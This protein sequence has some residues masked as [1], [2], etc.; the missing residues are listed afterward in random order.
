[1]NS[2]PAKYESLQET[3]YWLNEEALSVMLNPS[4]YIGSMVDTFN[5]D[6][7]IKILNQAKTQLLAIKNMKTD[8]MEDVINRFIPFYDSISSKTPFLETAWSPLVIKS[9]YP[10]YITDFVQTGFN[11]IH[12]IA[13]KEPKAIERFKI[14][15]L[16]A[17]NYLGS[18]VVKS[19]IPYS[20][21]IKEI[22]HYMYINETAPKVVD[23]IMITQTIYPFLKTLGN[24]CDTKIQQIDLI[25]EGMMKADDMLKA[26]PDI[27]EA[28]FST[29]DRLKY[30][31]SLAKF[32][33]E[34]KR[35]FLYIT[36]VF[37]REASA[38][39]SN[40]RKLI[41]I[42][43]EMSEQMQNSKLQ[44][45]EEVSWY[46]DHLSSSNIKETIASSK[47][48]INQLSVLNNFTLEE[49]YSVRNDENITL[50]ESIDS[51]MDEL[52]YQLHQEDNYNKSVSHMIT[53]SE[54]MHA[55]ESFPEQIQRGNEPN[56]ISITKLKPWF[57]KIDQLNDSIVEQFHQ[58]EE[59]SLDPEASDYIL[60]EVKP[61][62]EMYITDLVD[63]GLKNLLQNIRGSITQKPII[64]SESYEYEEVYKDNDLSL[65]LEESYKNS[66]R[67]IVF[68]NILEETLYRNGIDSE[69][70]KI[71]LEADEA[72][73]TN[74]TNTNNTTTTQTNN[75]NTPEKQ[76]QEAEKKKDGKTTIVSN[77]EETQQKKAI[78]GEWLK[79]L[80]DRIV[81]FL[82]RTLNT[83]MEKMQEGEMAE[84]KK[85][86]KDIKARLNDLTD[87]QY[88]DLTLVVL[89]YESKFPS[90]KLIGLIDASSK[91]TWQAINGELAKNTSSINSVLRIQ[92]PFLSEHNIEVDPN[93][94]AN[95]MNEDMKKKL[96]DLFGVQEDGDKKSYTGQELK[97]YV[98]NSSNY[99]DKFFNMK[100]SLEKLR[101]SLNNYRNAIGNNTGQMYPDNPEASSICNQ[102][103]T[104][105]GSIINKI[106]NYI[107]TRERRVFNDISQIDNF[108][109]KSSNNQNEEANEEKTNT[110]NN[111]TTDNNNQEENNND[112]TNNNNQQQNQ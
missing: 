20:K 106:L 11:M 25:I 64:L 99:L 43:Q 104:L 88:N 92:F 58:F 109:F 112:N 23:R 47:E 66:I 91:V 33:V 101:D 82:N 34:L 72:T 32:L 8:V 102:F 76:V 4:S 28:D 60:T 79:R 68:R 84:Q 77:K 73:N 54:E 2:I 56:T 65:E 7:N 67:S 53:E 1:M 14:F 55:L 29:I 97:E 108:F 52:T 74:E 24:T 87:A 35:L 81:D 75:N 62:Y 100:T 57:D 69:T 39:T 105:S 26:L 30:R 83:N 78:T 96:D 9:C 49:S 36:I 40:A 44:L 3:E 95:A 86:W 5:V 63:N 80:I 27:I 110:N 13:K 38:L 90:S 59:Q 21:S 71:I 17:D 93:A 48:V 16:N 94:E 42:C 107:T 6:V 37:D 46:R 15:L 61:F 22:L 12:A 10:G 41:V 111:E 85:E 89:D 70:I 31:K 19:S 50:L 51:S 103:A 45:T 98:T 18:K